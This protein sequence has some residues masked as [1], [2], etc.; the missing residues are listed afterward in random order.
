MPLPGTQKRA[1]LLFDRIFVVT[2]ANRSIEEMAVPP[3]LTFGF[4]DA[5]RV[6]GQRFIKHLDA[7]KHLLLKP[8]E[9]STDSP[10]ERLLAQLDEEIERKAIRAGLRPRRPPPLVDQIASIAVTEAYAEFGIEVVPLF[11][12]EQAFAA[13]YGSGTAV[14]YQ[15]ALLNLPVVT[16]DAVP[17][18]QVLAFREDPEAL[19]K[20]RD[21]R[22]WIRSGITVDSLS[23]AVDIIAQKVDDYA[24]AIRKHGLETTLG[25]IS[26]VLNW[27]PAAGAIVAASAAGAAGGPLWAALSGGLVI[28]SEITA[29]VAKRMLDVQSVA[30]GSHR[31]VAILYDARRLAKRFE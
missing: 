8:D 15:A 25:A 19:R 27:R 4:A 23:E 13:S 18:D 7:R 26:A 12:D 21:L 10:V 31:E 17:W 30:R 6:Y 9:L 1:A 2:E 20:Y 11:P 29:Y 5:D 24:W 22:L 3:Q 14:A 28:T 16:E